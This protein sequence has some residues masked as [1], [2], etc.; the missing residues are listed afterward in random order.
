MRITDFTNLNVG[1]VLYEAR[2]TL[3]SRKR[4]TKT[5][6]GVEWSRD[7]YTPA[8]FYLCTFTVLGKRVIES[9]RYDGEM[10]TRE[11]DCEQLFMGKHNYYFR[12]DFGKGK[13]DTLV[14]GSYYFETPLDDETQYFDDR[15]EAEKYI[16]ELNEDIIFPLTD[17]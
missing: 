10:P 12:R 5:F 9:E 4:V 3:D 11:Y 1:D 17:G 16:E 13:V 14:M 2:F 15:E 8:H 6:D 7:V